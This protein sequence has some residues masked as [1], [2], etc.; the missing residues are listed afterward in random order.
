MPPPPIAPMK[1]QEELPRMA[2]PNKT[3]NISDLCIKMLFCGMI[4]HF[5]ALKFKTFTC[6][7]VADKR[8]C[9]LTAELHM[10]T[11]SSDQYLYAALDRKA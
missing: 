7:K 10:A 1:F 2:N 8:E 3:S 9:S 6:T 11:I 5:F 4:G